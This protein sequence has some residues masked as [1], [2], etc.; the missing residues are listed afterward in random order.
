MLPAAGESL[1]HYPVSPLKV[2]LKLHQAQ[3]WFFT[4]KV[5]GQILKKRKGNTN[6]K[7]II[8]DWG[9]RSKKHN[10]DLFAYTMHSE[11]EEAGTHG[12][13]MEGVVGKT[14]VEGHSLSSIKE[15]FKGRKHSNGIVQRF[16]LPKGGR[17]TV[18]KAAWSPSM[19]LVE[20]RVNIHRVS[21]KRVPIGDR[22]VTFEGSEHLSESSPLAPA[23]LLGRKVQFLCNSIAQHVLEVTR[24]H[25]RIASMVLHFKVDEDNKLWLLFCSSLRLASKVSGLA[26]ANINLSPNYEVYQKK[27][28]V[29]QGGKGSRNIL[30]PELVEC[31]GCSAVCS[32]KTLCQVTFKAAIQAHRKARRSLSGDGHAWV[33][34]GAEPWGAGV[35]G[36]GFAGEGWSMVPPLLLKVCGDIPPAIFRVWQS[37]PTFLY[38]HADVCEKCCLAIT[39]VSIANLETGNPSA[40]PGPEGLLPRS[41]PADTR[42]REGPR[43]APRVGFP[44]GRARRTIGGRPVSAAP[45]T[46]P[47]GRVA[48]PAEHA[49]GGAQ[50]PARR[51]L[52]AQDSA[53]RPASR[54]AKPA[55]YTMDDILSVYKIDRSDI[56]SAPPRRPGAPGGIVPGGLSADVGGAKADGLEWGSGEGGGAELTAA[57]QEFLE[58][59]VAD[60]IG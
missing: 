4:S 53:K 56:H 6:T 16:V 20:R 59:T 24:G 26:R 17:N 40:F 32:L 51:P 60:S 27:T 1:T 42:S 37:D 46:R 54:P 23:A 34:G 31:P 36:E 30:I 52:T 41:P 8:E 2:V 5:N 38:R 45:S 13:H 47:L 57:E 55:P 28:A 22:L 48:P 35:D 58:S 21:D 7:E 15:F 11:E 44:G 43:F 18:I 14:T 25:C 50:S 9:K 12:I 49:A 39:S 19:C 29:I 3:Y 33:E 10:C